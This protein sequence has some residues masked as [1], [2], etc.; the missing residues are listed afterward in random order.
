M[1][2]IW[3]P[4][5]ATFWIQVG[6]TGA[7][8]KVV[9]LATS[10]ESGFSTAALAAADSLKFSPAQKKGQPVEAWTQMSIAPAQ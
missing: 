1:R 7:V 5:P 10:S 9:P 4:T 2:F 6:V 8:E 3:P